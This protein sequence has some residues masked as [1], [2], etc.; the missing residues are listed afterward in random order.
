MVRDIPALVHSDEGLGINLLVGGNYKLND[1]LTLLVEP[2]YT[3]ASDFNHFTVKA[4][5]T[6]AI[7]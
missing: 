4:G 7:K 6:Y 1:M 5:V 3:I 2:R